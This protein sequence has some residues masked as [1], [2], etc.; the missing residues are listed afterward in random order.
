MSGLIG[1]E[2]LY[3]SNPVGFLRVG[4]RGTESE[5]YEIQ[6][7]F[8]SDPSDSYISIQDFKY[9]VGLGILETS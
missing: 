7:F 6:V 4:S 1:R 9:G 5:A 2:E 3:P 8:L